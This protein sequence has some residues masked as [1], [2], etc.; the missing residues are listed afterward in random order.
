MSIVDDK[1]LLAGHRE[2]MRERLFSGGQLSDYELIEVLLFSTIGR[3]DVRQLA[4]RLLHHCGGSVTSVL[5]AEELKLRGVRGL[6]DSSIAAIL[7]ARKLFEHCLRENVKSSPVIHNWRGTIDYLRMTTRH[8]NKESL[9]V[10]YLNKKNH[11]ID[12]VMTDHGTLDRVAIY[13]R[14]IIKHAL[15]IGAASII[16]SHNHTSN[17]AD[18]SQADLMATR[19]LLESCK[20]LG[21]RLMDHIIVANDNYFSF[22]ENCLL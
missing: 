9:R 3:R 13:D 4:K 14:E 2:R 22:Q 8:S 10:L 5:W 19:K 12:D 7:C 21:I 20:V 11:V 17:D 1:Q 16:I 18:P 6:G 15:N